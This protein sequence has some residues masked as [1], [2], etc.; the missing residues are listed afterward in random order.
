MRQTTILSFAV[1][2]IILSICFYIINESGYMKENFKNQQVEQNNMSYDVETDNSKMILILSAPSIHDEYYKKAFDNIINFQI[3]YANK[4]IGN[5]NVKIIVDEDTKKYFEG[6]V[7]ADVLIVDDVY[8]IWMRD[9]TTVNPSQP[10]QFIYTAASMSK[11]ESKE[12]QNSF[13]NFAD[14]FGI[15][16][17][18]SSLIL[19]G[20]NIVDNHKGRVITTT[21]F[22]EDNNLTIEEGKEKL[23][24]VLNAKEVAI[25]EPDED[26]LAHA[27]GMVA[28]IDDN[29]LLVNKYDH[30]KF[31]KDLIAELET[32]FPGVKIVEVPVEFSQNSKEWEGF[33]SACG[34]N[35]NLVLTNN[36]V[37]VPTFNS[38][39]DEK[40]LK[41]IRENTSKKVIPVDASNICAMGGSVRC[42][43]WQIKNTIT[44][45]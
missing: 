14:N 2:L 35:L 25:I 41:I 11:S 15:K 30:E 16:R 39:N 34:V 27:D 6:K 12:V 3:D 32:S 10:V 22:L 21:R 7:S 31:R 20:G 17:E 1:F 18:K 5:D 8:D 19:D 33:N 9:F 24:E 23:K 45:D 43:T 42:L 26:V 37:Y 36:N 38:P 13:N 29:V 4:I 44:L 40:V 28:F